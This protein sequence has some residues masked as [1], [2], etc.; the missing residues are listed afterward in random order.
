MRKILDELASQAA[1]RLAELGYAP[2]TGTIQHYKTAWNKVKR[3]CSERG[4]V[5]FDP[6][7]ELRLIEDLGWMGMFFPPGERSMLRHIRTLL[8]LNPAIS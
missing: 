4:L 1:L 3:W 6:D 2:G 8:S 7:Q 5:W